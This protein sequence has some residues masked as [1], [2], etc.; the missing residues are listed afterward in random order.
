MLAAL[1]F[2]GTPF[3]INLIMFKV[4]MVAKFFVVMGSVRICQ[5]CN[6]KGQQAKT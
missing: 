3:M 2:V 6:R 1:S 5:C 4:L